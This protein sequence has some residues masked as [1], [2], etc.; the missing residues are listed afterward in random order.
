MPS[1]E[2][3]I[4][5]LIERAKKQYSDIKSEYESSLAQQSVSE[6]LKIDIKN[7]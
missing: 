5:A 6:N 4:N 7:L 2:R 1:R 3:Q